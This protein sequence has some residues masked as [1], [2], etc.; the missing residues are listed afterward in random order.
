MIMMLAD[1]DACH[2][3]HKH[4]YP[5]RYPYLVTDSGSGVTAKQDRFRGDPVADGQ[6]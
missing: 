5:I 3:Y 6:S 4:L 2:D 1:G